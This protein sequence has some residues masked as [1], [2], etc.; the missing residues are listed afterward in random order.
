M[1]I[2]AGWT[3]SAALVLGANLSIAQDTA[4]LDLDQ[5]LG[6]WNIVYDMGQGQQ[7]GTITVTKNDDGSPKIAMSTTG[8]G[9]S[10]ARDIRIEGDTITYVRDVSAQG[11]SLSVSY[12]AKLVGNVLEGSFV[13]DLGEFAG[14]AGGLGGPTAWKA[15]KVE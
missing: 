6:T 5:L 9:A 12:S 2:A 4:S 10:E 15:T 13:L 11:Q 7:T 14:A 3:L 8:G 1:K